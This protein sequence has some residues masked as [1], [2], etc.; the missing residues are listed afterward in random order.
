MVETTVETIIQQANAIF[1]TVPGLA[2]NRIFEYV[3]DNIPPGMLPAV[4]PAVKS[5]EHTSHANGLQKIDWKIEFN[6]LVALASTPSLNTIDR[7]A[8]PYGYLVAKAFYPHKQLNL[9]PSD[10]RAGIAHSNIDRAEYGPIELTDPPV[11]SQ[12]FVGWTFTM[13]VTV[14]TV[15]ED[16]GA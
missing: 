11:P 1:A 6:L 9:P 2:A 13:T 7:N 15:F 8:R 4:V 5:F 16:Y 3:P 10:T 14:K 12:S